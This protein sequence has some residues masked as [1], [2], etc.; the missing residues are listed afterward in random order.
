MRDMRKFPS[1]IILLLMLSI[2]MIW[3]PTVPVVSTINSNR[4]TSATSSPLELNQN[5]QDPYELQSAPVDN[6]HILSDAAPADGILDPLQVEQ[7]GYVASD[8]ISARTDSYQNLD[9]ALPLDVGHSWIGD[10]AEVSLWNLEKL[11]V[12]NGSFNLGTPGTNVNP[13]GSVTYHPLGWDSN[14]T[15]TATYDDDLQLS[16]YD[17]TGRQY[18]MVESQGGKVGQNEHGHV[19]G[20]R[21]VWT[22]TV[23]NAPYTEDFLLNFDYF[24]LRGPLDNGG[25]PITGNCSL[26]IWI[27]GA[28][29]W[30]MSLLTVGQRG[31]WTD[32]GVIPITVTGAPS[33]FL[34]EI[35]LEIDQTL[36]LDKRDDYD[37]NGI[38]DGIG[39]AAYITAFLDDISFLKAT[40]PTPD[41]VELQFT[42][43][44]LTAD[45]TG[46]SGSYSASITNSSYWD[47]TPVLVSLT[48]NTS[49]SFDYKTRLYAHRFTDSNWRTE[50]SSPG[51]AYIVDHGVS[52]DLI[53]YTYVGYLGDYEDSEMMIVFPDDWENLTI[54]DPF[55]TDLTSSCTVGTGYLIV[56]TS[57]IDSPG[58]WQVKLKSPNYAK[59]LKTQ[60][61]DGSWTDEMIFRID[62]SIRADITIGTDTQTLGLLTNVNITW[63]KPSDTIWVSEVLPP[64]GTSGQ[65]YST[66]RVLTSGS[67]PAGAW[68]VEV[69]WTN[70]T[71]VAY[72][73]VGFDVDHTSNLVG[74]PT[75][76][77][78]NAGL[79]IKGLV[80]YTDGDTNDPILD[81]SATVEG[82]WSG[83]VVTFVPN[84]VQNWWEADFDTTIVGAGDF[85]IVV[86]A[87]RPYYDDVSCQITV[88]SINVTRLS[89]PNAPWAAA[90]WGSLVSLTFNYESYHYASSSWGP[91]NNNSDVSV[92]VNWTA[93]YWSVTED[94][95]PGIY[96]IDLN[97]N[98]VA[99]GTWLLNVSFSK[100]Y[101]ESKT[102]LL[103]LI[104]SPMTSSLTVLGNL[105]ERVDIEESTSVKVQYSFSN[106][107][108][109][110]GANVIVGDVSPASGLSLTVVTEVGGEPGN[111]SVILTPY[112]AT[113]YTIRFVAT[114]D[115]SEPASTVFVLVV[116]DVETALSIYGDSSV[117]I[118]LSETYNTTF[119]YNMINGTGVASAAI[120]IV[121]SGPVGMLRWN[122]SDSGFGNYSIQLEA[123]LPGTYLITIAA[124]KQYHQSS[125]N[126]FFLTI[127]NIP[128][129]LT[130]PEV[131]VEIGLTD[132][133]DMLVTYEMLNGTGIE[134][135]VID[136][137]A[138][139]SVNSLVTPLG[140]GSYK[141]EFG[142]TMSG[143][144]LVTIAA[145]KQYH[146]SSSET[147]FLIVREI[148][149]NI[150]SLNGTSGQV[151]FGKSFDFL[152]E[153]TNSSGFGLDGANVSVFSVIPEIGLTWDTAIPHGSGVYSIL[154]TPIEANTYNIVINASYDNHRTQFLSFVLITTP[155]ATTLSLLNTSASISFDQDFTVYMLY[156]DEDNNHLENST[157][158]VQEISGVEVAPFEELG[159]GLYRVTINPIDLGIF[160]VIFKASKPGYQNDSVSFTLGST[161][162]PTS[163]RIASGLSSDS[164]RFSEDYQ[165]TLFYE[166]TDT[167]VNVS[168]ATIDVQGVPNS[169]FSWS[170]EES[171]DGY[172]VTI[173]PEYVNTWRFTISAQLAGYA[174]RELDFILTAEPIQIHAEMLSNLFAVEGESFNIR[175]NLT[176]EGTNTPVTGALVYFRLTPA[177]ITGAGD[178]HEMVETATPGI[179]SAF[180]SIPLYLDT[181]QYTLEI[182]VNKDN[183]ELPGEYFVQSF[184]K[185][186]DLVV[187]VTPF[188]SV[189]A[190][191]LIGLVSLVT[192]MR[193]R[194]K[195]RK[196]QMDIDL[197]NKRRFDDADNIIGV[198]VMHKTSGIPIYS[199]IVKGGFE[200]GIV[201]AFISAVTS[202]REEFDAIEVESMTVIPISDIIRAVQTRNLI[203]AFI[204]LQSASIEHNRKME[205]FGQ[206]VSTY[207]DDFYTEARPH[208][209]VDP[210]IGEVLDYVFD[211]TMDGKLIKFYKA[212]DDASFPR[213]LR[214][215]EQL[216]VDIDTRHC[217]RPVRL[218]KGVATYGVPES[219][220]CTLVLDAIEKRLIEP[221]ADDDPTVEDIDFKDFFRHK[222]SES[223]E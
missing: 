205:S 10:V 1:S 52:S 8:N 203:C 146:Q 176:E 40:P 138:P 127:R 179:Y 145:S 221:C 50:V 124:F 216:L 192:A 201:A 169:G 61:L 5:D 161:R 154:F 95:V 83:S 166:R 114:G 82:N 214:L 199:R 59:T 99:A 153:Y 177:G 163:L 18:V 92:N 196:A 189:G 81:A 172:I 121:Y 185:Y 208:S 140:L 132:S 44:G 174:S 64:G 53:M 165:F 167:D 60:V 56:P 101:H 72:D 46:S 38:D 105:S 86:N 103:T 2:P 91:V 32:V 21:I 181:T 125:S 115:Y 209:M 173:T 76:I 206:Q 215:L 198:I 142:S 14:S 26:K 164:V 222:N 45:L 22:Q 54:S 109:I 213:R 219:H 16:A 211:E 118:G 7:S 148:S 116:N 77:S 27:N 78:T 207:L 57:I 88:H 17:N 68:W 111:Y 197:A 171:G 70:G 34:F 191:S 43:G 218:A 130:L 149:T 13:T 63:F 210:R 66:P 108:P 136:V 202:F 190:V 106:G 143:S 73:R 134:G 94:I 162:I 35:G 15:D 193:F 131:S 75:E 188:I 184:A 182:K 74:D 223:A 49:V 137:I 186:N 178:L 58:W 200:E 20:T 25:A 156:Q 102:I 71:E 187:R 48:S 42:T 120:D 175:V 62:D 11:Y 97:T 212:A 117:E 96:K 84:P 126:S 183:Y 158:T 157:I 31:V 79:T 150:T 29:V 36:V 12:V 23:Q 168:S 194:S 119:R 151:G 107:T 180:Y 155:I 89:S 80:R 195:R 47:A 112:A 37:N 98:I 67:S 128:T 4:D 85:V 133:Y 139:A 110:S 217:A 160:D 6:L 220:G 3:V 135:A 204:T 65:I 122:L 30:N 159:A 28:P 90:E 33:S 39:N 19:A 152:L 51:V 123:S 87:S 170:Y 41:Q 9:Y 55:L 69:Y 24:Y 129:N 141:I 104:L 93:G 147:F 100:P 144:F 113:V